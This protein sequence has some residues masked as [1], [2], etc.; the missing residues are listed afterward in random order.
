[1]PITRRTL[2]IRHIRTIRHI[3]NQKENTMIAGFTLKYIKEMV[4]ETKRKSLKLGN[5]KFWVDIDGPFE[6]ILSYDLPLDKWDVSSISIAF[7]RQLT[8]NQ[9]ERYIKEYEGLLVNQN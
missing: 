9:T 3:L 2:R 8:P 1:M 6:N 4:L 7:M 5:V